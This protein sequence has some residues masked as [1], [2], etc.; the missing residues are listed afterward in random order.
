MSKQQADKEMKAIRR[1]LDIV[2]ELEPSAR[3]RVMAFVHDRLV[4]NP[5]IEQPTNGEMTVVIKGARLIEPPSPLPFP[6]AEKV[7]TALNPQ[8][9]DVSFDLFS[10]GAAKATEL[11]GGGNG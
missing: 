7:K 4:V 1:V 3:A 9:P 8:R 6:D 5:P 2:E 11:D 10:H